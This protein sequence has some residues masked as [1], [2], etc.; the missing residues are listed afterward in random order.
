MDRSRTI[1]GLMRKAS[2][3]TI[4]PSSVA[5]VVALV[6]ALVVWVAVVVVR[7]VKEA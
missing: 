1:G 6:V 7:E 2:V 3:T 5:A 4:S